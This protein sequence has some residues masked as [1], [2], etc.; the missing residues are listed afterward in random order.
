MDPLIRPY[1][2][3]DRDDV[4][5]VCVLTGDSGGDATGK[6]ADDALLPYIYALPYLDFAPD[7]AWVVDID[8][9]VSGYILG[10]AD[11]AEF[12]H[13]WK[14]NWQP[15]MRRRFSH[16]DTWPDA[17]QQLFTRTVAGEDLW[18][19]RRVDHPAEFHIDLLPRAQGRGLGRALIDTFCTALRARGVPALAIGVGARNT[20]AVAFYQHMGLTILDTQYADG[21]AIGHTLGLDLQDPHQR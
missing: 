5:R 4:A 14:Q 16:A 6:F 10:V 17:D 7:L 2:P 12:A 3:A 15:V 1:R 21:R 13:W 20:H 18:S 19:P 9:Q 11:V 8:G